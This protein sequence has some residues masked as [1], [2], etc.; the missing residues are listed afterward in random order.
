MEPIPGSL[1]ADIFIKA[2]AKVV[3][4]FITQ[5]LLFDGKVR[6]EFRNKEVYKEIISRYKDSIDAANRKIGF[7]ITFA[8]IALY[9]YFVLPETE[10]IKIPFIDLSVS[11]QMWISIAPAI[12]YGLEVLVITSF[13]WFMVLRVGVKIIAEQSQ[14]SQIVATIKS[15]SRKKSKTNSPIA[16]DI[17]KQD[18]KEVF[19]DLTNILLKGTLGDLWM[20]FRIRKVFESQWHY[21]WY[22]P[23]LLLVFLATLSPGLI[24]L[25][26]TYQLFLVGY[27][28]LGIIYAIVFF[29]VSV[30]LLILMGMVGLLGLSDV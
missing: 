28:G 21:F 11:R 2:V 5:H 14:E 4:P 8:V 29:P 30:L 23:L 7:T 20:I 3:Q 22:I 18:S 12:S 15:T 17:E 26:F 24:S 27:I 16:P 1:L 9:V 13:L 19:A 25:F 10:T 6:D